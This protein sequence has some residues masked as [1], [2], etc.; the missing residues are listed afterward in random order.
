MFFRGGRAVV[1]EK[2]SD[3]AARLSVD[4]KNVFGGADLCVT[5]GAAWS[6]H[7]PQLPIEL[8]LNNYCTQA[9]VQAAPS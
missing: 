9:S 5:F 6:I 1:S 7:K 8:K 4:H 3:H 2:R